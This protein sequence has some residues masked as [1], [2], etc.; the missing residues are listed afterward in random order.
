MRWACYLIAALLMEAL[1]LVLAPLLP[2]FARDGHLPRWLK[3]FETYDCN[4]YGDHGWQT[5]HVKEPS[6]YWSQVQ[7][8]ARNRAYTFK[9]TVLSAPMCLEKLTYEGD[10]KINRNNGRFGV[11]RV[12]M[13]EYWQYKLVRPLA[14][15]YCSMLNFGWL[16][17]DFSQPSALFMFSPRLAR[18]KNA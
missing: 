9:W 8:L 16:L 3:W 17:D 14:F 15:G 2:A 13:G 5:E 11:L 6:S 10:L 4:L 12:T 7:W 1:A 18:I